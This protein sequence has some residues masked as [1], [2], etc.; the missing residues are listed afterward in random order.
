MTTIHIAC[1][2]NDVRRDNFHQLIV[3]LVIERYAMLHGIGFTVVIL[4]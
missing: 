4:L 2:H 1:H 3:K